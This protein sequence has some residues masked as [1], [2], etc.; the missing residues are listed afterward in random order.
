[1]KS[2]YVAYAIGDSN[3]IMKTTHPDNIDYSKD[4]QSWKM[5]IDLFCKETDFFALEILDFLDGSKESFVSFIAKLSS[6]DMKE[7]SR[8]LKV[9]GVWLYE[10]GDVNLV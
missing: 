10:S 6:G 3:Y 5:S 7:R 4:K 2:R 1:M 9:D 8:F